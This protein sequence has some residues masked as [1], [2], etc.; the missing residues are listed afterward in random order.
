VFGL[1]EKNCFCLPQNPMSIK[2]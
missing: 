1:L 2:N